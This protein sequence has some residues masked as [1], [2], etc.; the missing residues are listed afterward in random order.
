MV[1]EIAKVYYKKAANLK[2]ISIN[3]ENVCETNGY[4]EHVIWNI[5]ISNLVAQPTRPKFVAETEKNSEKLIRKTQ[6]EVI[7]KKIE[8]ATKITVSRKQAIRSKWKAIARIVILNKGGHRGF[9]YPA[10]TFMNSKIFCEIFPFHFIFDSKMDLRQAG[11]TLQIYIQDFK[12]TGLSILPFFELIHP[13]NTEFSYENCLKFIQ[14]PHILKC[15]RS[16]LFNWLEKPDL[17]LR[18]KPF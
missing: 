12:H 8:E 11:V 3:D 6:L 10:E 4:R 13:S 18:Y 14:T 2:L 5:T 7:K 15:Q 16:K 17:Y 1:K 9:T